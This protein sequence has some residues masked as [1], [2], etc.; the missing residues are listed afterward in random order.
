MEN[1]E[2]QLYDEASIVK[3]SCK[4]TAT[5]LQ[6]NK[7]IPF[8]EWENI[9]EFLDKIDSASCWWLG[10][11]LNYGI[12]ERGE[13]AWQGVGEKSGYKYDSLRRFSWIAEKI[14]SDRRRSDLSIEHHYLVGKLEPEKQTYWLKQATENSWTVSELRK[15]IRLSGQQQR[16]SKLPEGK[17]NII[18]ADPPWNYWAGGLKNASK[19]YRTAEVDKI[20]EIPVQDLADDNCILFLWAT[21]PILPDALKLIKDWGFE[22]STCGFVWIKSKQDRTGFAFGC[23]NWTRANT[24]FVLIATKG[25]IVRK[26]AS[27]SQIIYEPLGEHSVKPSIVRD[28][29]VQLVGDLPRIE[30]FARQETEGW[31]V[32]GDE[33]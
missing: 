2:I 17:Y 32:W 15:Q 19:Y 30:L 25:N 9:G 3:D 4:F 10:D 20:S 22:Y 33:V 13:E 18:L 16:A 7:Q 11:W 8:E 23:G 28:K 6:I 24:E 21:W 12:Q 27:I 5:S 31:K 26:D 1:K 29:I 14:T